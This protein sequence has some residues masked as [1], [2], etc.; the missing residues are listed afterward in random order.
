MKS[1]DYLY[2]KPTKVRKTKNRD[3]QNFSLTQLNTKYL[4]SLTK[5]PNRF[6]VLN[7]LCQLKFSS[8]L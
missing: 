5:E 2:F 7:G 6:E 3:S 1:F 4:S 8:T